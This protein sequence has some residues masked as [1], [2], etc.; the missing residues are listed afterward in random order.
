MALNNDISIQL[1]NIQFK[2][3]SNCYLDYNIG[4]MCLTKQKINGEIMHIWDGFLKASNIND[5]NFIR[6][7]LSFNNISPKFCYI[8]G[9]SNACKKGYLEIVKLLVPFTKVTHAMVYYA[10]FFN[11]QNVYDFLIKQE[12][13]KEDDNIFSKIV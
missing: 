1:H 6:Y 12:I 7:C 9:L 8:S 2:K 10:F 5:I 4:K 3:Y 13:N 11:H